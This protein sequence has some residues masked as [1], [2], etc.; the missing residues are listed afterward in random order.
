M[1]RDRTFKSQNENNER[2][3]KIKIKT[4]ILFPLT[5][6]CKS[7]VRTHKLYIGFSQVIKWIKKLAGMLQSKRIQK[8]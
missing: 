4:G 6:W 1:N 7:L 5:Q 2:V 3:K 8:S